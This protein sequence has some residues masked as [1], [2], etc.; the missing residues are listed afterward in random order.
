MTE[1]IRYEIDVQLGLETVTVRGKVGPDAIVT[2]MRDRFEDP[3][4]RPGMNLLV[5]GRGASLILA[6]QDVRSLV[7]FMRETRAQRGSGFR[8]ALVSDRDETF[9][10]GRML[11]AYADDLPEDIQVF[12]DLESARRWVLGSGQEER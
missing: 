10:L 5:D 12:R 1:G 3:D 4:H 8:F 6:G 2:A 11:Q 9:G 7:S